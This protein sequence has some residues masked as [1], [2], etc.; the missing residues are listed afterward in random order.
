MLARYEGVGKRPTLV[1]GGTSDASQAQ[2]RP[3][4]ARRHTKIYRKPCPSSGERTYPPHADRSRTRRRRGSDGAD[5]GTDGSPTVVHRERA[6]LERY[7]SRRAAVG[8]PWQRRTNLCP[9]HDDRSKVTTAPPR[10]AAARTATRRIAR[11]PG[12]TRGPTGSG[13]PA[14]ERRWGSFKLVMEQ[15]WRGIRG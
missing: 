2:R 14:A 13:V 9:P 15:T 8:L 7:A 1:H 6:D 4:E 10:I 5:V 12:T 11:P 3:S